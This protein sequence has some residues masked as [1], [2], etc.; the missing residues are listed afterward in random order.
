MEAVGQHAT[1]TTTTMGP[2][3][4]VAAGITS[5]MYLPLAWCHLSVVLSS[6]PLVR[7]IKLLGLEDS[8]VCNK[9][10]SWEDYSEEELPLLVVSRTSWLG[11]VHS[12]EDRSHTM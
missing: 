4:A 5:W 11:C 1:T 12:W 7:S 10:L 8:E 3:V 9:Q 6:V 2:T